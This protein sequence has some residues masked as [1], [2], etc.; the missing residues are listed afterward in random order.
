V[1]VVPPG[2]LPSSCVFFFFF[3]M[4]CIIL[5]GCTVVL[6]RRVARPKSNHD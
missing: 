6:P 2:A 1:T 3:V 4:Y 5:K